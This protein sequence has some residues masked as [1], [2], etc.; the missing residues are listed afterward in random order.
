[1]LAK[2]AAPPDAGLLR[3]KLAWSTTATAGWDAATAANDEVGALC[4]HA[5][6]CKQSNGKLWPLV[7]ALDRMRRIFQARMVTALVLV[8]V[9][10]AAATLFLS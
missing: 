7:D 5:E 1:M 6:S 3:L 4:N 8:V 10:A 9:A 2:P